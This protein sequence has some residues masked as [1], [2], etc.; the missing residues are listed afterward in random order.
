MASLSAS[1]PL[2]LH[3]VRVAVIR[4]FMETGRGSTVTELAERLSCST[5][6]VRRHLGDSAA[7]LVTQLE[8]RPR[9]ATVYYPSREVLREIYLERLAS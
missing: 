2:G 5:T 9:P 6:T 3:E 1:A 8:C 7:G 4:I